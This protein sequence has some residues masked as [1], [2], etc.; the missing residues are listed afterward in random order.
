M[1]DRLIGTNAM[2]TNPN[3]MNRRIDDE[4]MNP[5]DKQGNLSHT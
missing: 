5:S 4:Q 3:D 2:Q 1:N